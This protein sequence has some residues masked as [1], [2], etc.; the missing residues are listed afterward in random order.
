MEDGFDC[1][2]IGFENFQRSECVYQDD[3]EPANE[4]LESMIY[5]DVNELPT[6]V[7]ERLNPEGQ[8][9]YLEAFNNAW[10]EAD[11]LNRE[12]RHD[13]AHQIGWAAANWNNLSAH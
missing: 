8:Q 7:T 6:H 2:R 10:E 4:E 5:K 1:A 9:V 13:Y 12:E 3:S 11:A